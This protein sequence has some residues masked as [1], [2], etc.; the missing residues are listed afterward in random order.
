MYQGRYWNIDYAC[1]GNGQKP[2]KS[3][4]ENL[5]PASQVGF[6]AL[7]RHVCDER[8]YMNTEKFKKLKNNSGL[9]QFRYHD[10][11]LLAYQLSNT[12]IL[13]NGFRKDQNKTDQS[14]IDLAIRIKNEDAS[15]RSL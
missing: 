4:I 7:L 14:Y 15:R 1:I 8:V 12:Y 6:S 10:F 9:W 5:D 13:T 2:A 11:R 3:F